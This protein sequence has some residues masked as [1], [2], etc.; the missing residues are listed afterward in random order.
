MKYLSFVFLIFCSLFSCAQEPIQIKNLEAFTKLYGYVRYFHPS[1]EAAGIEWDKFA[2]YGADATS[3]ATTDEELVAVL[4]KLFKP[5]AP[6]VVISKNAQFK[7]ETITPKDVSAYKPVYWFH[8]GVGVSENP[9]YTS[10]R[11]NRFKPVIKKT[12][13]L[14]FAPFSQ[15]LSSESLRGKYIRLVGR[16]KADVPTSGGS[17]H[18]WLRVD[19]EDKSMGFFN[20]MDAAPALKNE[21][22][23]YSFEGK[24]NEDAKNIYFGGFL[25]ESGTVLIDDVQLFA[26]ANAAEDWKPITIVN[27]DFETVENDLPK[28]WIIA[29]K[30][31]Y[32]FTVKE[33]DGNKIFE[34]SSVKEEVSTKT[35]ELVTK[36]DYKHQPKIGEAITTKLSDNITAIV[37]IVLY[38]TNQHTYPIGD[39]AGLNH[40]KADIND[41]YQT[42]NNGNS[43]A[44][45]L[46]NVAITW[47]IF[48]HFFPYWNN[49]SQTP[50]FILTEALK[51][52]FKDKTPVEFRETLLKMTAP[53]NDGHIWVNLAYDYSNSFT[54][55]YLLAWVE[56]KV[57][58]DKVLNSA[59]A[60]VKPG[61]VIE[62]INGKNAVD[63]YKEKMGLISGSPQWKSY[64]AV[65]SFLNGAKDSD[66]SLS[67]L[68][69]GEQK[70]LTLKRELSLGGFYDMQ[71]NLGR[72]SGKVGE[73]VYY[74]D[75]SK[76][77]KDT[78]DKWS[79]DLAKAKGI[80]CDLR[81]YPTGNHNLIN[82]LLKAGEDTKWMFVPKTAYPDQKNVE[83]YGMGWDMKPQKP[84]IKAKVIFI[85]DGRAI[86]YA[87]SYMGFIKDF[88]LATIIG[89]P[90]AGTNG[91]INPFSLPGGYS[92][93]W[94]GMLVK[95]HDGTQHHIKGVVPDI[96]LERT[97]EGLV[98]GKDEF[99]DEALRLISNIK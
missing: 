43:L 75:I 95:N 63:V 29:P 48:K 45:R 50:E 9:L 69:N 16:M 21:W 47:N 77:T 83:F 2:I 36:I 6:S 39:L 62:V 64:N 46:G 74:L 31:G 26:R 99:Y 59:Y 40:L 85:T 11:L 72:E 86:S 89:Q 35:G 82:Y 18:F 81:G 44:L 23:S 41:F 49:A 12:N 94:T 96:H 91:N 58:V 52:S 28:G 65:S 67:I 78:I 17:G 7:L 8:N 4:N 61:D 70:Q 97:V 87:E 55:P 15:R 98:A 32:Q 13:Q 14:G 20:N 3:K 68:R 90:T 79:A 88:K 53:L 54:L 19:R 37:P 33:F 80:I 73:G 24:V 25:S 92:V 30:K 76:I 60:D 1:D 93:S 42:N 38:G 10:V 66:V 51:K 71:K 22:T 27:G 56:N 84:N 34:I 57:V 5:I